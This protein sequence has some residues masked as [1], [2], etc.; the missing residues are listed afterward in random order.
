MQGE[1]V[2]RIWVNVTPTW[3]LVATGEEIGAAVLAVREALPDAEVKISRLA[4]KVLIV[5]AGDEEVRRYVELREQARV[6]VKSSSKARI[7]RAA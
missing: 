5:I 2:L 3:W 7:A 4:I 6:A 1:K